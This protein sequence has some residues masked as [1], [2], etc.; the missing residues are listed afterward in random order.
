MGIGSLLGKREFIAK[1][2]RRRV[3][4]RIKNNVFSNAS[5]EHMAFQ[6]SSTL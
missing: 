6:K 1:T 5:H 4:K 2:R 3:A